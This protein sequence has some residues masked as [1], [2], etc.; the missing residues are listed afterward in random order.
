V[1][2]IAPP[3][4]DLRAYYADEYR[5]THS[6]AVGKVLSP[7]E[8]F[9]L[10]RP[11]LDR[12]EEFFRKYIPEGA[13]VLEIG[14]SSGYFLDRI[15]DDYAVFGNEWNPDDAAFVRD[16]LGIPCSEEAFEDAYP[17]EEFTA[18]VAYQVIEHLPDPH[19]WITAIKKRLIGGGWIIV[20]T[21]NLDN[22]LVSI[23]DIPEFKDFFFR[24]SHITYF[25]QTALANTLGSHGFEAQ[26]YLR[27][28][29][30]FWN[31]VHWLYAREP[32]PDVV[33]ARAPI[34]PIPEGHPAGV[35]LNRLFARFD[36]EYHTALDT[37]RACD[38]LMG[39]GRKREI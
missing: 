11:L 33:V 18:I 21:P 36:R 5:K 35:I 24:E 3:H 37:L 27:Q 17:G 14:C 12:R 6:N 28:D 16:E 32:Q 2:Y 20:E 26:V 7:R 8:N 10:M 34:K 23:Y 19:A 15:R 39:V 31:T 1:G 29:Y 38:Y 22:A 25:D 13:K 30:S 9:D 4:N